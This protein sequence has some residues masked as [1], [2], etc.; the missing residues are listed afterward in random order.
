[1]RKEESDWPG[2]KTVSSFDS[3]SNGSTVPVGATST[4]IQ[5]FSPSSLFVESLIEQLCKLLEKEPQHQKQMYL[6]ICQ[7]LHQMHLIDDSYNLEEYESLRS[8]YQKAL[9]QLVTVAKTSK[10]SQETQALVPK[11]KHEICNRMVRENV[12]EWSRYATEFEELC[13]I[14]N[15]GFGQVY[16]ARHKLDGGIYAVKK[17][18]LRY[19]NTNAFMR[20]LQEVKML[21][22]LNHPNIVAYKAAWLEP[23]EK[24]LRRT[25]IINTSHSKTPEKQD[26]SGGIVFEKSDHESSSSESLKMNFAVVQPNDRS[27]WSFSN[28]DTSSNQ[29]WATLYIQMQLCEET[30]RHWLDKRNHSLVP[31]SETCCVSM[32]RKIVSGVEYIHSQGIVHH[33]IKPSNIFVSE[34]L[35]QVQVGDFGLAC[36]LLNHTEQVSVSFVPSSHNHRGEIGTKQYAAPE[37]LNGKCTPKSDIFSL[38]VLLLEL[39]Q[40]FQTDMERVKV[41]GQLRAGH[42][43]TEITASWPHLAHVISQTVCQCPSKR[44]TASELLA[45]LDSEGRYSSAKIIAEKD[46]TIRRLLDEAVVREKEIAELRRQLSELSLPP[47]PT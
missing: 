6:R 34:D 17:I 28:Q 41:I 29:D 3:G 19:H 31:V 33:D 40:P 26:S 13:F 47:S 30:L 2:L 16:Q 45:S 46:E 11:A 21:A 9:Y 8:Y 39:I 22:R 42:I 15:G 1:M 23:L 24:P 25:V 27:V 35:R 18:C 10:V 12:I 14:A 7:K 4:S 43:P 20:N 36:S 5:P 32:F 44:P 37:Q 38:G